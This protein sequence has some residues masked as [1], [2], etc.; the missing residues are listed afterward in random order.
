MKYFSARQVAEL[1]SIGES[2]AYREMDRMNP[3]TVGVRGKRVSESS[4][5]A[6]IA[7]RTRKSEAPWASSTGSAAAA[8]GT[9]PTT[10]GGTAS[11]SESSAAPRPQAVVEPSA[12]CASGRPRG[13]I[14]IVQPRPRHPRPS[15]T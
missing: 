5:T 11:P 15:G 7:W 3:V 4:L 8:S 14:R 1:L 12:S 10:S 2:T 13:S 9:P 6:Y